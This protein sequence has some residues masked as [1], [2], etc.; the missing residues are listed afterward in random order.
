MTKI[1]VQASHRAML[2]I[3]NASNVFE[4]IVLIAWLLKVRALDVSAETTM[5]F[6]GRN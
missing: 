3:A 6:V 4:K 1:R 5:K 2:S